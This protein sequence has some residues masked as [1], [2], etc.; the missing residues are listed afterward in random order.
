MHYISRQD[1]YEFYSKVSFI[2]GF[3]VILD[4]IQI[5][6]FS[7]TRASGNVNEWPLVQ[8]QQLLTNELKIGDLWR[9]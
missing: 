6:K 3:A 4:V 1:F 9:F 7:K 8:C 2:K 5:I